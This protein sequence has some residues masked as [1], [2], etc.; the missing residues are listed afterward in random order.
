MSLTKRPIPIF[1]LPNCVVLPGVL[2]PLHIFE[3]RYRAMIADEAARSGRGL[4]AMAL[5]RGGYEPHY[6]SH[7]APIHSTLC[8]CEVVQAHAL[9]DGRYNIV[10][11][12]RQRA[13]IVRELRDRSYRQAYL[14]LLRTRID[15]TPDEELDLRTELVR[16]LRLLPPEDLV[17]A[18]EIIESQRYDLERTVDLLG[19]HLLPSEVLAARQ[20]LLAEQSLGRRTRLAARAIK[21]YRTPV[22]E[23]ADRPWL[24]ARDN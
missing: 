19:H 22:V 12:G 7:A 24:A 18:C 5:L 16:Q 6:Y 9:A 1:P 14:Q 8:V 3:P 23:S 4:I 21:R 17:T 20:T 11:R 15:F 10:I 13:S 2:Q